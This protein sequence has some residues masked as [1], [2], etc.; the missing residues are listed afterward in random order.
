MTKPVIGFIGLG[1]MGTGFVT[2]LLSS[3]YDVVGLDVVTEKRAAAEALGAQTCTTPAELASR[4]DIIA[5]CVTK[6]K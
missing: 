3:G 2:R 5:T 6:P 1:L 4:A